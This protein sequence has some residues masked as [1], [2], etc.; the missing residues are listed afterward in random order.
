MEHIKTKYR[1]LTMD[2]DLSRHITVVVGESGTG[3]T[4]IYEMLPKKING[5]LIH[6]FTYGATL[7]YVIEEIKDSSCDLFVFDR[8]ELLFMDPLAEE[9][10]RVINSDSVNT[11][12]L[13]GRETT[14][15]SV[16]LEDVKQLQFDNNTLF[17]V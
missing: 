7:R 17:L 3:K 15:L 2:L 16:T 12:L 8:T 11:F 4:L 14:G 5:T 10:K 13:F 6:K 1:D 9:L